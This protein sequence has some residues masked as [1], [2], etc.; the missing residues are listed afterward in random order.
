MK[1]YRL[2]R[3]VIIDGLTEGFVFAYLNVYPA[4]EGFEYDSNERCEYFTMHAEL[5]AEFVPTI[6]VD[7]D[8]VDSLIDPNYFDKFE[9]AARIGRH[10][11]M[12]RAIVEEYEEAMVDARREAEYHARG[13]ANATAGIFRPSY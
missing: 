2:S 3:E 13:T 5:D 1:F 9:F 11:K 6:Y 7:G 12:S 4:P 10:T 8:A